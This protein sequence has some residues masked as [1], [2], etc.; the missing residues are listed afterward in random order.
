MLEKDKIIKNTKKYF[1]TADSVGFMTEELTQFL[2]QDFIEAPAST[3]K[4]LNT[5]FEGGL[6]DHLLR[7]TKFGVSINE[8][9]PENLK[10]KKEDVI[11]VCLLYQIG[12]A[13][14]FTPCLSEWHR[15]NQGKMYEFNS[16]I[17]SMRIGERS[18]YYALSN[19]VKLTELEYQ[20]IVNHDKDD[21][22]KQSKYHTSVLGMLLK[23]ANEWAITEEKTLSNESN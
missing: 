11:K 18:A 5:A 16:N 12:K 17:L 21:T 13:H 3:N 23:Q 6:I 20:A 4:D 1:Q 19:G 9:L 2:G 15:N 10:L 14:A 7:T 22:D 8:T